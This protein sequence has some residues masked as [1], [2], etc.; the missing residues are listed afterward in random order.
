MDQRSPTSQ[1][2]WLQL[3]HGRQ[4][5][6]PGGDLHPGNCAGCQDAAGRHMVWPVLEGHERAPAAWMPPC[7]SYWMVRQL[8]L[9]CGLPHG[10][11]EQL[12]PFEQL[13]ASLPSGQQ[14]LCVHAQDCGLRSQHMQL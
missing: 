10:L 12:R 8:P 5:P 6:Q 3:L 11:Q 14:S 2:A 4:L 13:W 1:S 7:V 9:V